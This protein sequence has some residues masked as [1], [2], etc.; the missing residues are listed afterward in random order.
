M[1]IVDADGFLEIPATTQLLYFYL[2]MRADDERFVSS[3][4]KILSF[5][6]YANDDLKVLISK[7]FIIPSGS[8]VV[9]FGQ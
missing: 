9:V 3:P 6:N 4:R 7:G 1:S 8:G 2:G 5:T